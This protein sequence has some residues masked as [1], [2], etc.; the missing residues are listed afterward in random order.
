M[1]GLT[2]FLPTYR[3]IWALSFPLIIASISETVVGVTDAIFLSHYGMTELAALGLADSVYAVSLFLIFGFADGI[4]ITIG[5]RA[6]E[7]EHKQIGRVLNQGLYILAAVSSMMILLVIFAVP[8]ATV[9]LF[10][11]SLIHI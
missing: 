2:K 1:A 9:E 3:N 11:L 7:E 4:Q 5:R 10:Q 6:G 8:L